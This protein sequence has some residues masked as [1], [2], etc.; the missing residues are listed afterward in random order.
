MAARR[1]GSGAVHVT[2]GAL[3]GPGAHT[4]EAALDAASAAQL[5]AF[6]DASSGDGSS[7]AARA[8]AATARET[9]AALA[10][11]LL[12][13]GGQPAYADE[14]RQAI[15][16]QDRAITA[17]GAYATGDRSA[18]ALGGDLAAVALDL[19]GTVD[20]RYA[21]ATAPASADPSLRALRA[22]AAQAGGSGLAA[23][24]AGADAGLPARVGRL[25]GL[26]ATLDAVAADPTR[27]AA[28]LGGAADQLAADR[29][30]TDVLGT[31][32]LT[33]LT[34][35]LATAIDDGLDG[36][37]TVADAT[38]TLAA[39][40]SDAD[41]WTP[42]ATGVPDVAAPGR[43]ALATRGLAALAVARPGALTADER[44]RLDAASATG[45]A[46]QATLAGIGPLGDELC[47]YRALA[48][49]AG[50][51]P[52]CSA[53]AGEPADPRGCARCLR[54]GRP[55]RDRRL[56][57]GHPD[58]DGARAGRRLGARPLG[59]ADARARTSPPPGPRAT[60]PRRP[61][62]SVPTRTAPRRASPTRRPASPARSRRPRRHAGHRPAGLRARRPPRARLARAVL[63]ARELARGRPAGRLQVV[64]PASP[65]TTASPSPRRSCPS[66][67]PS[68]SSAC[69]RRAVRRTASTTP[70]ATCG[71][72]Q[73]GGL[74]DGD[75][76]RRPEP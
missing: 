62:G 38:S 54:T 4:L 52:G 37:A 65:R 18:A 17:L 3:A 50:S 67:S 34:G 30:A 6:G 58:R 40:V 69:R 73:L 13:D 51:A 46:L 76:R 41:G 68:S 71:S 63:D 5:A 42:A 2:A 33:A 74:L 21:A 26:A 28:Q 45:T 29:L 44:D 1:D 9:F 56:P 70:A 19:L 23:A 39:A 60:A 14:S 10:A 72:T 20:A 7:A 22:L 12:A 57:R 25:A 27:A 43:W 35:P 49:G 31:S 66:R 15:A 53:P 47:A 64:L 36:D 16:A 55:R 24:L 8:S 48:L 32:A 11:G 61:A 75:L 59:R